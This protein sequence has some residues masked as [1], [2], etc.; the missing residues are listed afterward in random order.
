METTV[1]VINWYALL[2]MSNGLPSLHFKLKRRRTSKWWHFKFFFFHKTCFCLLF[3]VYFFR[4]ESKW[5]CVYFVDTMMQLIPA[6]NYPLK[7]TKTKLQSKKQCNYPPSQN[8]T[9]SHIKFCFFACNRDY[10]FFFIRRGVLTQFQ[11]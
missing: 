4:D 2:K 9:F 11:M 10:T 8:C 1:D 6:I 3:R 7:Q 5:Y